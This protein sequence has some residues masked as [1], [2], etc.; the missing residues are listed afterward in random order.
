MAQMQC[1]CA[2]G[3]RLLGYVS[4]RT[5]RPAFDA[6]SSCAH[7][8]AKLCLRTRRVM[9][10][11]CNQAHQIFVSSDLPDPVLQHNESEH[12]KGIK[13]WC[14]CTGAHT[15]QLV[16]FHGAGTVCLCHGKRPARLSE[17]QNFYTSL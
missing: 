1:A 7:Q 15:A 2:M 16:L 9:V 12:P 8:A 5:S 10:A 17:S 11:V 6:P 13:G 4:A 14:G 3:K